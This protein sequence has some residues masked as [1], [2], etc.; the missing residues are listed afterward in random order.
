VIIALLLAAVPHIVVDVSNVP[1]PVVAAAPSVPAAATALYNSRCILCHGK[2]GAGDGPSAAG[3]PTKP[4][5]FSDNTWQSSVDDDAIAA[6]ILGGGS[7][8]KLS[9][10]MPANP[11]LKDKPDVVKGLVAFVRS[12]RAPNGSARVTATANTA[13]T[14]S[15]TKPRVAS[16]D[17]GVDGVAHIVVD[18][19]PGTWH[20]VVDAGA[21]AACT[22]D[23]V[24]GASD[25]NMPCAIPAEP[26]ATKEKP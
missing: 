24:V 10:L 9:I 16:A 15:S 19:A 7:V 22:S 3:L 1:K 17:A 8:R 13:T 5:R 18:A 14:N 2:S 21:G 26:G 6:V 25:V 20:V 12:L 11:D 4:R 23:V